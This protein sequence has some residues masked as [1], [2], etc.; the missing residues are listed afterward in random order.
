MAKMLRGLLLLALL[1]IGSSFLVLAQSSAPPDAPA[2]QPNVGQQTPQ[3]ATPAQPKPAAQPDPAD[4]AS[5]PDWMPTGNEGYEKK[6]LGERAKDQVTA[7]V[8]VNGHCFGGKKSDSEKADAQQ[9]GPG[10]NQSIPR[11]DDQTRS[12]N[13]DGESSSR[14][15]IIDLS[16]PKD[17]ARNHPESST[18]ANQPGN[19]SEMKKWDPHR[20]AKNVEV[21]D[22]YFSQ[23]NY[24]AAESRYQEALEYKDNF[25]EAMFKL[26][27]TEEKLDHPDEARKY[28]TLSEDPARRGSRPGRARRPRTAGD[29]IREEDAI[30]DCRYDRAP[31]PTC[32][33]ER[34]APYFSSRMNSFLVASTSMTNSDSSGWRHR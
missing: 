28:S 7:P 6:S 14:Q 15:A 2:P 13:Q 34:A 24:I 31:S 12:L 16:P 10:P 3:T 27:V 32:P 4:P 5:R 22:Y 1:S 11:S 26:A 9:S 30:T 33:A 23:S 29:L 21:G 17:D 19:V 8:C 20:A 25:A 18:G